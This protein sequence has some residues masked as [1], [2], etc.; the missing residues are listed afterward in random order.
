MKGNLFGV[1]VGP[2]DKK[3]LT[4]LAV[5]TL[6][7]AGKIVVPD[8]G[9][10]NVS[11]NIVKEYVEDK[12]KIYCKMPMTREKKLLQESHKLCADI[13]C[14]ELDKGLDLA[15]I[16]L[17]DPTIYST[18][19]YVHKLVR[20]RGYNAQIVNGIPSFCGAA[21]KLNISLCDNGETLHIIPASYEGIDDYLKIKGNKVLMKS[22][23]SIFKVKEK[24]EKLNI[25]DRAKMVECCFM[26][27]ERIYESLSEFEKESSYFSTIIVKGE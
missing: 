19:M 8:T 27:N 7:N 14:R 5:E 22:G 24:L 2:G 13:I 15:F 3:L 1:G 26:E 6:K 20:D 9:G 18:Y 16:T 17:G 23:K 21:A 12:E 11:L 10:E 4:I 25:L